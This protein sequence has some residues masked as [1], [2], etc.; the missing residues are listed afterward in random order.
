MFLKILVVEDFDFFRRFICSKLESGPSFTSPRRRM[1]S[2]PSKKLKSCSR[3]WFYL[4][5][6][7]RTW[8]G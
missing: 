1:A 7:C 5:L 3:T 4:I 8:T 6:G 2:R